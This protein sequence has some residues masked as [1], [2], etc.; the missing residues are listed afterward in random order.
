MNANQ[1]RPKDVWVKWDWLWQALFY[2]A[3]VISAWLMLLDDDRNAPI[4]VALVLT[5]FL[6]LWYWG[7]IKLVY[8]QSSVFEN[9]AIFRFIVILGVIALWFAL[10]NISPAYYF[11]LFGLFGLVFTICPSAT[12]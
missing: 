12:V 5:G 3:V 11:M 1:Q 7:G 9:R 8:S 6:L 10:V 4:W 2:A